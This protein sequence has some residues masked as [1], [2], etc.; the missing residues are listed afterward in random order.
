MA[1][2]QS[3]YTQSLRNTFISASNL[4]RPPRPL[5]L[6]YHD[7]GGGGGGG[8][9]GI[10]MPTG[11]P[12]GGGGGG[13]PIPGGGGGGGG[14]GIAA[15]PIPGGGGTPGGRS[16]IPIGIASGGGGGGGG[17]CWILCT[18]GTTAAVGPTAKSVCGAPPLRSFNA[19]A[20]RRRSAGVP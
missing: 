20:A 16:G 4:A 17:C 11:A 3:D 13:I 1:F 19:L 6:S 15:Y 18:I 7:G 5:F 8:G 9:G 12:I 2:H 14:C 10:T